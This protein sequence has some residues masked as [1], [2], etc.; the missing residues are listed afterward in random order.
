MI[1]ITR[2]IIYLAMTLLGIVSMWTTYVSLHDSILPEPVIRLHLTPDIVWDCS[3]FA[4]GLSVAIGMM[5]FALKV[6]IIDEQKRL[7]WLGL[8]GLTVVGFISISFNLDVLYR[9]ADRDFFVR[10]SS[11]KMRAVYEDYLKN[12]QTELLAKEQKLKKEVAKQEG[13]LAAEVK[14]LR[15]APEGY[16]KMAKQEDYKLTVLQ[17]TAGVDLES[18]E[19]AIA[20]KE[21][22]DDL[23]RKTRP[24]KLDEVDELQNQL[25]VVVK[26]LGAH[27]DTPMPDVVKIESPLFVVFAK[28][29]DFKNIGIK[30]IFFVVIAFFL[31][32]GD[33]IGYSLIPNKPK[34]K[35]EPIPDFE[36]PERVIRARL[37][38]APF[39]APRLELAE[40][41]QPVLPAEEPQD[42]S[43]IAVHESPRRPFGFRWK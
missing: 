41:P 16:G 23:L 17:K 40:E 28:V 26:D 29:F 21:E 2:L 13:E 22:A 11:E 36:Q 8:V 19:Q 15:Q 3:I 4:L 39:V 35:Q 27:V 18:I 24:A 38:E 14:G 1:I 42:I 25:R 31:D 7:N 33:I 30:E 9:T 5:L 34:R 37:Q 12:V 32:L 6:A 43:P 20:K 10:Y